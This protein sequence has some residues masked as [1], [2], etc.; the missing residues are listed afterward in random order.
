MKRNF[1]IVLS[2]ILVLSLVAGCT[3][4][5]A[6]NGGGKDGDTIRIGLNFAASGFAATYGQG[7]TKGIE[8]AFEEINE[9]GGLFDKKFEAVKF[10]NKSDDTEAA[11]ISTRLATRENV[12]AMLGSDISGTT[13]A[14]IPAA[15]ENKIPLISGSATAD[16]VTIDNNG[17]VREYVFKTCF[18]DSFQGD[19]KSTRLNS[20]HVAIS[21]AVFCLKKKRLH[22]IHC[23]THKSWD[24][25]HL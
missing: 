13:K 12:V 16:D 6:S 14:A 24:C 4:S 17:N 10:D 25:E 9:A 15:M 7:L 20:S 8:L 2:L 21:Y 18:N 11:N 19:R 22:R 1:L 5:P 3:S 23:R